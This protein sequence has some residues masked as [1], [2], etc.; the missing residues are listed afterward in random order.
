MYSD[1]NKNDL[2]GA[3]KKYNLSNLSSAVF[4]A[5]IELSNGA[6]ITKKAIKK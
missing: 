6:T 3:L 1:D 4:I 2:S 5:K